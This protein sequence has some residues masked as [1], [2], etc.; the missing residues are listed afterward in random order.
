M[1]TESI[2]VS[3]QWQQV[4]DNAL[5]AGIK[6]MENQQNIIFDTLETY[7]KQLVRGKQRFSKLFA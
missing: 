5:K 7:K 6:L 3:T 4:T 1:V 2:S